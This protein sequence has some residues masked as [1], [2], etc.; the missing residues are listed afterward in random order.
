MYLVRQQILID[1]C[2][3]LYCPFASPGLGLGQALYAAL[4]AIVHAFFNKRVKVVNQL[5]RVG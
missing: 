2:H 1:S 5:G 3:Y 4:N